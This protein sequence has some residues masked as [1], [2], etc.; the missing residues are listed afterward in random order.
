MSQKPENH[1]NPFVIRDNLCRLRKRLVVIMNPNTKLQ[2]QLFI[3]C[4]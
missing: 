2:Q 4:C 3:V 1:A